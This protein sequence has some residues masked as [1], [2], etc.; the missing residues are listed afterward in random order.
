M[1]LSLPLNLSKTEK[2]IIAQNAEE[3]EEIKKGEENKQMIMN[4]ETADA[5]RIATATMDPSERAFRMLVDLGMV[6]ITP[7]PDAPEY[8]HSH[9]DETAAEQ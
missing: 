9:D 6:N 5:W 2:T 7:D 3:I 1:H 4:D 8:D